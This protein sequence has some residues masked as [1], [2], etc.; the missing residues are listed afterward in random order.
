[1]LQACTR[2]ARADYCAT[3]MPNTLDGTPIHID[4]VFTYGP[5]DPAFP[6]EAAWPG[7]AWTDRAGI[8]RPPVVCLS[9]L[10]WSTLPLGGNCAQVPDPRTNPKARFCDDMSSL[11]MEQ[12]GALVYSSSTFIDAGLYTYRDPSTGRRFTTASLVPDAVGELPIWRIAPPANVGF[13]VPSQPAPSFEATIFAAALPT[14][15]PD[16]NL[17]KLN[18]YHC[19]DGDLITTTTALDSARCPQIVTEGWVYPPN[20]A[21]FAP[22]RRWHLDGQ[23]WTTATAPSTMLANGWVLDEVVGGVPR[24]A[25]DVNVRWSAVSGAFLYALDVETR[26]GEW[27]SGC[28]PSTTGGVTSAV[29]NGLCGTRAV[30]HADVI[31]FRVTASLLAQ[32]SVVSEASYDGYA[33][34]AYVPITGSPQSALALH[35]NALPGVQYAIDF[36]LGGI[37]VRCDDGQQLAN[38][39]SYVHV[40]ECYAG[41]PSAKLGQVRAARVCAVKNGVDVSC[42]EQPYAGEPSLSFAL[43]PL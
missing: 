22:L 23:I 8:H 10:R 34:D 36:S 15:I 32:P 4:D 20:T 25:L 30:N 18:S 35:W 17:V 16:T 1:M 39:T 33:S 12:R 37:W 5:P 42:A 28:I 3:G 14:P 27:I 38:D 29:F 11:E 26:A 19:D 2:M 9:K 41:G 21:G 6:F 7:I 31:A 43:P 24:A 13:P 40:Q